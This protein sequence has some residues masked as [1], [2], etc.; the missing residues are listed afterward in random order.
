MAC[1]HVDS[2][3]FFRKFQGRKS[4]V[5]KAM[6]KQYCEGGDDCARRI[7]LDGGQAPL[8]DDLMPVGVHASKTFLSLP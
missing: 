1:A 5:W 6:L 7:M 3:G 8:S 4:L 2:C